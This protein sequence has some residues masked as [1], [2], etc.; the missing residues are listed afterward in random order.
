MNSDNWV[1]NFSVVIWNF[2]TKF[3]V[4]YKSSFGMVCE[5]FMNFREPNQDT[6]FISIHLK[7]DDPWKIH[8]LQTIVHYLNSLWF[9]DIYL[10]DY[11]YN[12][13]NKWLYNVIT[14]I[15]VIVLT[16]TCSSFS[17]LY[18]FPFI[19]LKQKLL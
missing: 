16:F 10:C 9:I 5:L 7:I 12:H 19:Y 4:C 6:R 17:F 11:K 2:R 14:V 1:T 8:F 18:Y 13:C 15:T 3:D